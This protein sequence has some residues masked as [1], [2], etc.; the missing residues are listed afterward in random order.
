MD[1]HSGPD[2]LSSSLTDLM[3]SLMVIFILLLIVFVSHTANKD[4]SVTHLLLKDLLV[5]LQPQHLHEDAVHLDPHDRNA[6]LVIVPDRLVNF[7]RGEATL[8]DKGKNFLHEFTPALANALCSKDVRRNIDS[9]VVEGHTD[10]AQRS[11]CGWAVRS[12]RTPT[13]LYGTTTTS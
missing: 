7:D 9:I 3:T 4:A 10:D 6:I 11:L 13:R 5:K 2:H 8:G 1:E 12:D